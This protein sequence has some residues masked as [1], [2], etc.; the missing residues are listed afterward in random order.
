MLDQYPIV[1]RW[2]A[3]VQR[4]RPMQ[5]IDTA[6]TGGVWDEKFDA[7]AFGLTHPPAGQQWSGKGDGHP[8][9]LECGR[10]VK[11]DCR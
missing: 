1:D 9:T 11:V 7:G 3:Q 6:A 10:V 2:I 4:A 8:S 5:D